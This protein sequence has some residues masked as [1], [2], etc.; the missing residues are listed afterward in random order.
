MHC[1]GGW[2]AN[3]EDDLYIQA[4]LPEQSVVTHVVT[5]GRADG[6]RWVTSYV[7]EALINGEWT[8]ITSVSGSDIFDGNMDR[9]TPVV[10]A[11]G[12]P[13]SSMQWRLYPLSYEGYIGL[14]W[15]LIEEADL[16][17]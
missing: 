15:G 7:L 6:D 17:Q 8:N 5:K 10:H 4:I 1:S 3:S 13:V 16:S 2:S 12:Q 14:R 9:T 11:F